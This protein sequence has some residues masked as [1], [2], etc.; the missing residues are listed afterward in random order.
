MPKSRATRLTVHTVGMRII[1]MS[2]SGLSLRASAHT[3]TGSRIAAATKR[4]TVS[5][6]AQPQMLALADGEQQ[7]D[8]P[9]R[10]QQRAGDVDPAR[11]A[12]GRL[13]HEQVRG[14]GGQRAS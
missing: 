14:R 4:P 12:L 6:E 8:Q 7:R 9:R 5:G 13:G 3:Q 1:C 11:R 10:H 2:T